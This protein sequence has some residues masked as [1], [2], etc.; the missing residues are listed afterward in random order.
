VATPALAQSLFDTGNVA[1][2]TCASFTPANNDH[3]CGFFAIGA[4]VS[5]DWTVTDSLGGTWTKI[6]RSLRGGSA[7][8]M[9]FWVRNTA[10]NGSAMTV[11]FSHAT[12]NATGA[13]MVI[14]KTPGMSK[15]GSTSVKQNAIQQNVAAGG[16]PAVTFGAACLTTNPVVGAVNALANPAAVTP[17]ASPA[18]TELIDSGYNTPATGTEVQSIAS[19]FTGTTLT[20]GSTEAGGGFCTIGVELDASSSATNWTKTVTESIGATD[21][22]TRV[23]AFKRAPGDAV[24]GLDSV[25]KGTGKF[26]TDAVGG[27]DSVARLAAYSRPRTDV[28]GLLDSATDASAYTRP[29]TD[30]VGLLDSVSR[31]AAFVRSRTDPVGLVDDATHQLGAGTINWTKTVSDVVGLVDAAARVAGYVRVP[32]ESVGIVDS[33]VRLWAAARSATDPVGL[34]DSVARLTAYLRTRT[35]PVG[36]LDAAT[37]VA[38]YVRTPSDALGLVDNAVH[39]LSSGTS[40][41]K[42]VSDTVGIVDLAARVAGYV[43]APVDPV[44]LVDSRSKGYGKVRTDP[45]GM[46]DSVVRL[47]AG[48]RALADPIGLVDAQVR[49]WAAHRFATDVL[50]LTDQALINLVVATILVRDRQAVNIAPADQGAPAPG[51]HLAVVRRNRVG[52]PGGQHV[53]V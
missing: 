27:L 21:G 47:S 11:T 26:R 5:T 8:F 38:A 19:G 45:L 46:L 14:L 30:V 28:V 4:E 17:T 7:S 12:G 52:V 43:R 18:F 24:G 16:T 44:G 10:S 37:R 36:L 23:A 29:T 1:T 48:H 50:G 32:G 35:D 3:L 2:Y 41:T 13:S 39:Q 9:E 6:V 25:S 33:R 31:L 20:W 49:L 53:K 22:T 15:Y 42:S 51:D 40:W 34:V